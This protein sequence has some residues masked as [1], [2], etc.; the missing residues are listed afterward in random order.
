MSMIAIADVLAA[1]SDFTGVRI[2]GLEEYG[3]HY[4]MTRDRSALVEGQSF[5]VFSCKDLF[6]FRALRTCAP[7]YKQ[8]FLPSYETWIIGQVH[9]LD[10]LDGR[11]VVSPESLEECHAITLRCPDNADTESVTL[12]KTQVAAMESIDDCNVETW[13]GPIANDTR[14]IKVL[15]ADQ[16][17]FHWGARYEPRWAFVPGQYMKFLVHFK[18]VDSCAGRMNTRKYSAWL[19]AF[20]L[21]N[22]EELM[23]EE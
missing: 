2:L 3:V 22:E 7:R 23:I 19:T 4:A 15:I 9:A 8:V 12:F 11:R 17:L 18:R 10:K 6:K 1:D 5:Q 21:L 20:M 14:T 16:D 13:F